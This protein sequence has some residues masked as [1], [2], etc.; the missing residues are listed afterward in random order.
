MK[1]THKRQFQRRG[2]CVVQRIPSCA[3]FFTC[4]F[5]GLGLFAQAQEGQ[6]DIP[7]ILSTKHVVEGWYINSG[8]DTNNGGFVSPAELFPID[9]PLTVVCPGTTGTCSIQADMWVMTGGTTFAGNTYFLCLYVDGVPAPNCANSV[10]STPSDGTYAQGS[11]SE[12]VL[13]V[14]HGNHTVQTKIESGDGAFIGYYNFN[15]RVLKP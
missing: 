14:K 3:L 10:G 9:S 15:Y 5:C 8:L 1:N 7:V 11:T 2:R 12:I 6:V 4:L 13:G